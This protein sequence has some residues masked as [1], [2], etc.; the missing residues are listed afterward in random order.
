MIITKISTG[1]KTRSE[2]T[3][4]I[5]RSPFEIKSSWPGLHVEPTVSLSSEHCILHNGGGIWR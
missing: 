5:E 1:G 2:I 4:L 3:N